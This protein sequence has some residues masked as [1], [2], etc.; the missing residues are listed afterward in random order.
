MTNRKLQQ[1]KKVIIE[2]YVPKDSPQPP[3][4]RNLKTEVKPA[5]K[6]TCFILNI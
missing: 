3:L 1:S 5:R 4:P 6:A 2:G